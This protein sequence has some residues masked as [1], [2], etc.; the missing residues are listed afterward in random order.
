MIRTLSEI[1]APPNKNYAGNENYA[2]IEGPSDKNYAGN[3][4]HS[5]RERPVWNF[6]GI[7]HNR[8]YTTIKS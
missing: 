4:Q 2:G 6:F 7:N 3:S 5:F 1:E 8:E